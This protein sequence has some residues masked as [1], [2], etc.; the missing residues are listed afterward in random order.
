MSPEQIQ[1]EGLDARSNLFSWGAILYEMV[2]DQKAF[3]G[4]D[5]DDI[6][7]KI[8]TEMPVSPALV[9]PKI[10]PVASEV[11]MKALAKDPAQR[12]Q[13]GRE[14]AADLEKCREATGKTAKKTDAP[15]A[16]VVPDA[17]KA[18][19]SAKLQLRKLRPLPKSKPD[20]R[21]A[22]QRIRSFSLQRTGN[23]LDAPATSRP[24]LLKESGAAA[25]GWNSAGILRP[26]RVPPRSTPARSL[27]RRW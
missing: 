2:T 27:L 23:L 10:N 13:S 12:Y 9:N 21:N 6:R 26:R 14:L 19:A 18:S 22:L 17:M 16:S 7:N 4:A 3:D 8:V 11:I 25:A 24:R 15:K 20:P 5:A 1:G